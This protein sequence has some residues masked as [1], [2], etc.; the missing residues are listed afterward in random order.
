MMLNP[1]TLLKTDIDKMML[2]QFTQYTLDFISCFPSI[3]YILCSFFFFFSVTWLVQA[4]GVGVPGEEYWVSFFLVLFFWGGL[5]VVVGVSGVGV[6]C[7]GLSG[8]GV[9]IG[10]CQCHILHYLPE[11]GAGFLGVSCMTGGLIEGG[12]MC[13][14]VMTW[15]VHS[16]WIFGIP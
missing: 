3:F 5:H 9:W 11:F 4:G 12:G 13:V 16:L 14:V 15:A 8:R 2:L 7:L 10:P 1:V 6:W